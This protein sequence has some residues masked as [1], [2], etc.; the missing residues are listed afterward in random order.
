MT[1]MPINKRSCH[2]YGGE[3]DGNN[4][5]TPSSHHFDGLNVVMGDDAVRFINTSID[6]RV[7]WALGG[8]SD[9]ESVSL[10]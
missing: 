9:G 10:E 2:I 5:I 4:I 3:D 6:M 7:W 1:V 8:S